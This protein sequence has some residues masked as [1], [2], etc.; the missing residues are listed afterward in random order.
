MFTRCGKCRKKIEFGKSLC[1]DCFS[2]VNKEN[3]KNLKNKD[4]EKHTKTSKW[5]SIRKKAIQRD[6]GLCQ[7]CLTRGIIWNKKLE[8]HHIKKRDDLVNTPEE[9]LIYDLSNLVS[10]CRPCHEE[11]EKLSVVKQK[12]LLKWDKKENEGLEFYL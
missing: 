3:K 8:V 4:A 2:K 7:L 9:Y 5:Q 10:V 6:K 12:E 11:L 1:D